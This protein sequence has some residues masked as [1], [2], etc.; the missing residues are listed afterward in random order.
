MC[1][2]TSKGMKKYTMDNKIGLLP[3]V[4]DEISF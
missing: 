1:G 2:E 4:N 3:S